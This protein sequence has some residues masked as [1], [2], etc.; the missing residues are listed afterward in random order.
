MTKP[1]P[2]LRLLEFLRSLVLGGF[3]ILEETSEFNLALLQRS[4]AEA[5]PQNGW[6]AVV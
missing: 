6:K 1:D 2:K 4:S 5:R 3:E